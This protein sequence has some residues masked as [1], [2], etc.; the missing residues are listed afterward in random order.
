MPCLQ[1]CKKIP[2]LATIACT[3]RQ[4]QVDLMSLDRRIEAYYDT[5][6]L[7]FPLIWVE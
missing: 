4:D 3:S 5:P 7:K 6:S 2:E 1:T